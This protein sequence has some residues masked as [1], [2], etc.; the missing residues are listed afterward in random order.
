M[1]MPAG[2]AKALATMRWRMGLVAAGFVPLAALS[3]FALYSW[4][5]AIPGSED[6][7]NRFAFALG[8]IGIATLLTLVAGVE[9]VAHER[10]FTPAINPL[11]GAEGPGLKV[12]LR[13]LQNTLEQ[14]VIFVPALLLQA[15]QAG[16]GYEM[17]AVTATAVVW[18]ALRFIFWIGYR[19]GPQWRTPGLVGAL[20]SMVVL[21]IGVGRFGYQ[22]AGWP[23]ALAPLMLF[24]IIEIVLVWQSLRAGR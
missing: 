9:A 6:P 24:G 23:G 11:A 13:Y 21:M 18:I 19:I 5:P 7:V 8:W 14:L 2:E 17:R 3:W 22:Y 15:F 20:L 16:D 12:N 1:G 4:T 10:L